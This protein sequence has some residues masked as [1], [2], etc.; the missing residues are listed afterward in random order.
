[1][2]RMSPTLAP[3]HRVLLLEDDLSAGGRLAQMLREDGY[4]VELVPDGETAI[5]RLRRSPAP[6]VLVADYRLPGMDGLKVVALARRQEPGI[7]VIMVTS[8]PEVIERV[9]RRDG[10]PMVIL[11]KPLVYADLVRE[12]ERGRRVGPIP[13]P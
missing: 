8:Y 13:R 11:A 3:T 1:M 4:E 6:D 9:A 5:S 12:L 10:T 2:E 7:E